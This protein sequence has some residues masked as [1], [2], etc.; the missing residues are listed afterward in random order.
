MLSI[1]FYTCVVSIGVGDGW[2]GSMLNS[3][4]GNCSASHAC[5]AIILNMWHWFCDE[6]RYLK[7]SVLSSLYIMK[8]LHLTFHIYQRTPYFNRI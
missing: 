8:C 7:N 1:C 4:L 5:S 3:N 6:I 2:S